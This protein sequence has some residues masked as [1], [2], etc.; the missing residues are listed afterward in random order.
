MAKQYSG[1][2]VNAALNGAKAGRDKDAFGSNGAKATPKLDGT[3]GKAVWN[4]EWFLR[5]YGDRLR[6]V[7]ANN[8]W[9]E[10]NSRWWDPDEQ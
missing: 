7:K 4:R 3:V 10:W 1:R 8:T 5:L 2:D 6:Y 9:Y